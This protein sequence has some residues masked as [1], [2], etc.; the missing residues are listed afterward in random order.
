MEA[1]SRTPSD[2]SLDVVL[3]AFERA[4]RRENL[5][6]RTVRSY[7][8]ALDDLARFMRA[9]DVEDVAELD[10]DL[11]ERWQDQLRDRYTK[12]G[13]LLRSSTR[14][15]ASTAARR[16]I[17]WAAERDILDWK[18][19]RAVVKVHTR[20][21]D[22]RPLD[23]AVL[24]RL[25]MHY[26]QPGRHLIYMRDRAM[27][28][29]FITSGA[30]V[31]E[32]LQMNRDDYTRPTVVQKGGYEKTLLFP[33]EAVAMMAEYLVLRRDDLP[34]MWI[35]LGNNVNT[36]RRLEAAGVRGIWSRVCHELSLP[37]FTTHQLRH[38][39]ATEL[40]D[41]DVDVDVIADVMGHHDLRTAM[42]YVKIRDRR[43]A[44]AVEAAAHLVPAARPRLYPKKP[45][46]RA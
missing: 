15:I 27:F 44:R 37:R 8:W 36:I 21:S 14:S 22:P 35:A 42:R 13:T 23:R 45:W 10:R 38:S 17:R 20:K 28:F 26:A 12:R 39:Y 32:L 33:T 31:T 18:V 4:L 16:L 25:R 46:R 11:I 19:E 43:R 30:R 7:R 2:S 9:N 41:A 3:P 29:A 5:S 1:L 24:D 34:H 6:E 40:A